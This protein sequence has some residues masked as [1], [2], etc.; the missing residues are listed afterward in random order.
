MS[1]NAGASCTATGTAAGHHTCDNQADSEVGASK[2]WWYWRHHSPLS[3]ACVQLP[4]RAVRTVDFIRLWRVSQDSTTDLPVR[5]SRD[6]RPL[7]PEEEVC[8]GDVVTVH[9]CIPASRTHG[10]LYI[11][12]LSQ[13]PGHAIYLP[14]S[15]MCPP[16]PRDTASPESPAD[17]EREGHDEQ[18]A[19][20]MPVARIFGIPRSLHEGTDCLPMQRPHRLPDDVAAAYPLPKALTCHI[21]GARITHDALQASCCGA[22]A[23]RAAALEAWA[24]DPGHCFACRVRTGFS[25]F[26]APQGIVEEIT[27]WENAAWAAFAGNAARKVADEAAQEDSSRAELERL[28][29]SW[30]VSRHALRAQLFPCQEKDVSLDFADEVLFP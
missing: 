2:V 30:Q 7:A 8:A 19:D 27:A 1:A 16:H 25:T 22:R 18:I 29:R 4:S 13:K 3:A 24:K 12:R 6:R 17:E 11:K 9:R 5:V 10:G 20:K 28:H 21:T 14:A 23:G 26:A 15:E